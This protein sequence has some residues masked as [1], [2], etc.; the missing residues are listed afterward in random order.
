MRAGGAGGAAG[1]G[2]GA[3]AG[4]DEG[5]GSAQVLL[6][7]SDLNLVHGRRYG[8]VGRNGIGKSTL[9]RHIS[10]RE[11][12]GMDSTYRHMRI[13]HVAQELAGDAT[14]VVECVLRA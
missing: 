5:G 1:A 11:L 9:L 12:P 2:A 8:L 14:P 10:R 13:V 6:A 7:D 3:D 4:G